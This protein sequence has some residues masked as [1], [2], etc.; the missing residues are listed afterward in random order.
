MITGAMFSLP[1]FAIVNPGFVEI[2]WLKN[3]QPIINQS[4][5]TTGELIFNNVTFQDAGMYTCFATDRKTF[6]T[7]SIYLSVASTSLQL[8]YF[9][10][11][12]NCFI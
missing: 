5:K 6:I 11:I 7:K 12:F 10:I 3:E 1:C 9:R 2:T 8:F 4:N